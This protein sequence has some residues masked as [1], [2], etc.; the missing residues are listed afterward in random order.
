M[1]AVPVASTRLQ[2]GQRVQERL[3]VIAQA[4]RLFVDDVLQRLAAFLHLEQLVDLLLV[5]DHGET[6]A[7]VIE[8][9]LHLLGHRVL[10]DRHRDPTGNL[11]GDHRPVE[12][13]TVVADD[14]QLVAGLE[15]DGRQAAGQGHDLVAHLA[16]GPRLPD[17]EILLTDRRAIATRLRMVDKQLRNGVELGRTRRRRGVGRHRW[18]CSSGDRPGRGQARQSCISLP[19]PLREGRRLSLYVNVNTTVTH[20]SPTAKQHADRVMHIS[21]RQKLGST[22]K[23]SHF[24]WTKRQI[25]VAAQYGQGPLRPAGPWLPPP[26]I[27]LQ[28]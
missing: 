22:W 13:R 25:D 24:S 23:F 17:A 15:A 14:R 6:D 16:P 1:V 12:L 9:V 20:T 18:P 19:R 10:V 11:R 8:D 5:L 4:T 7:R 27:G 26:L 28:R 2:I 21:T 3:F